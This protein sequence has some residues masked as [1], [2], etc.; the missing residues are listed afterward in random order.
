MSAS[1]R[2][3]G[4]V[5]L[6]AGPLAPTDALHSGDPAMP[7]RSVP[8]AIGAGLSHR[9]IVDPLSREPLVCQVMGRQGEASFVRPLVLLAPWHERPRTV[10]LEL[11]G[12]GEYWNAWRVPGERLM[13]GLVETR[14]VSERWFSARRV[15]APQRAVQRGVRL[16]VGLRFR[17]RALLAP[18]TWRP[19][20]GQVTQVR[21]G[22]VK[23]V[24]VVEVLRREYLAAPIAKSGHAGR[25][26]LPEDAFRE[27]LLA[28]MA[29]A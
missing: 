5:L 22:R 4:P 13:A 25:W 23:F 17:H 24:A 21:G 12:H 10:S 27:G 1:E 29:R 2:F 18:W 8:P 15:R 20:L 6:P 11:G 28:V 19:L 26:Q 9:E 3:T 7:Q 16:E 14:D